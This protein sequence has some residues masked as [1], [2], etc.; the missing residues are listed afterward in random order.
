M[1]PLFSSIAYRHAY[2]ELNVAYMPDPKKVPL[3]ASP[4]VAMPPLQML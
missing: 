4:L 1:P 3:C 2:S